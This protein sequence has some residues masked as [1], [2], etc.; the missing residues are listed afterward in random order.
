MINDLFSNI[1]WLEKGLDASWLR[2][3]VIS[4][5]IA[6]V[7]TVGFKSSSVQ[8]ESAF[9]AALESESFST[10][11]TN[12]KHIDFSN[13]ADNVSASVVKNDDTTMRMDGNNVDIDYQNAELAKNTIYFNTLVQQISSEFRRLNMAIQGE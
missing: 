12:E 10:T 9:K 11:C 8:F 3:Q 4:N 1:E 6:N 13:T 2:G 7:D 5:N